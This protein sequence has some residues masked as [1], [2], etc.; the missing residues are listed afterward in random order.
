[1]NFHFRSWYSRT[2][3]TKTP[4][5]RPAVEKT[6]AYWRKQFNIVQ[7]HMNSG[8]PVSRATLDL[9]VDAYWDGFLDHDIAQWVEDGFPVC[10]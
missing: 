8:V 2:M 4:R 9:F 10:F 1:M 3:K 7:V 6:R 5:P